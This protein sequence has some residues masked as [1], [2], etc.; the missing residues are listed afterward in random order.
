MKKVFTR[1]EIHPSE[2]VLD[3]IR[4]I[5]RMYNISTV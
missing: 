5:A 1:E 4:L 2:R 3:V